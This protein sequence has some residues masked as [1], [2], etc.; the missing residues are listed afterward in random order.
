VLGQQDQG[1]AAR[2]NLVVA[3][4]TFAETHGVDVVYAD[5]LVDGLVTSCTTQ[6]A[7]P[8]ESL[9]CIL[10]DSGI[11]ARWMRRDQ[12]VLTRASEPEFLE[13]SGHVIDSESGEPLPGVH[14]M[15]ANRVAGMVSDEQGWFRLTGLTP[16]DDDVMQISHVGYETVEVRITGMMPE[17]MISLNP[18][19]IEGVTAVVEDERDT[20]DDALSGQSHERSERIRPY[21]YG[22]AYGELA[23]GSGVGPSLARTGEISGQFVVRGGLPHHNVFKLDGAPVYQPWHSQGLFSVLQ[24]SAVEDIK[25]YAGSLPADQGG[26]L[27]SVL[28][29]ELSSG[30]AATTGFGA[31]STT[32]GEVA[33]ST[34]VSNGVTAMLAARHSH[35][36]LDRTHALSLP[37]SQNL[38]GGS[39]YDLAAK[40]GVRSSPENSFSFTAYR[41]SDDLTWTT[42]IDAAGQA[43]SDRWANG[44]YSFRHRYLAG[45]RL[46]VS[47]TLYVSAFDAATALVD[48]LGGDEGPEDTRHMRDAGMKIDI[49]YRVASQHTLKTGVEVAQHH[50]EWSDQQGSEYYLD[51]VVEG[52][53]FLQDTWS[54]SD[55]FTVRPGLRMS[56]FGNG[57]G[58][59]PEPRLH[60]RYMLGPESSIH[61]SWS[62]QVQ[63]LHHV[64]DIVTGATSPAVQRWTVSSGESIQPSAGQQ[65]GLGFT[66]LAGRSWQLSADVYWQAFDNVFL[67]RGKASS[68]FSQR[69]ATYNRT[70]GFADFEQG[71]TRA[72]GVELAANYRYN[73]L[74]FSTTYTAS[75]SLFSIPSQSDENGFRPSVYDTPLAVRSSAGYVGSRLSLVLSAE[76][77]TGYPTLASVRGRERE[78]SSNRLPT[79]FRLDAAVGYRF[80][81]LGLNWDVQGRIYNLTNRENIVG[82]E[83]DQDLLYL[84]RTSLLGVTRWPTLRVQVSW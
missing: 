32:V 33:F 8:G 18:V 1:A 50:L 27:A 48:T 59:R 15:V 13:V 74:V 23:L 3:L 46:M 14:V 78:I 63:Y 56:W 75:R 77:R 70:S 17:Q 55:R 31:L 43:H 83:Y 52:A 57:V 5:R 72:F 26:Y 19:R 68:A 34:P 10:S 38:N 4:Q 79:Y 45:D 11:E 49:D 20:V 29:A 39:F 73:N 16:G 71:S 9:N 60:A 47:N 24:P 28:D 44:V 53:F 66:T 25:L 69:A 64:T 40:I 6:L 82:Y 76:A 7:D 84:R 54:V 35:P 62:R 41:G 42:D 67:P 81:R 58:I 22:M 12:V 36:G 37:N 21:A 51:E 2:I 61:A 30:H 80:K 65:A